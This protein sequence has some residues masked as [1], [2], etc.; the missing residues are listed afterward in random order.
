MRLPPEEAKEAGALAVLIMCVLGLV[1]VIVSLTGCSRT[2]ATEVY[3][4]QS[5]H[6]ILMNPEDVESISTHPIFID[7]ETVEIQSQKILIL[8][9]QLLEISSCGEVEEMEIIYDGNIWPTENPDYLL[10]VTDEPTTPT[11]QKTTWEKVKPYV[12]WG[13]VGH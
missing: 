10:H 1:F 9:E 2:Q 7:S 12:F 13:T 3:E 4:I 5:T 6:P 11:A 8:E